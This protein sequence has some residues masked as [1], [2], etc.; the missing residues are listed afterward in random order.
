M[1]GVLMKRVALMI[2]LR[3]GTPYVMFIEAT[4]AKWKVLRVI[5]VLGSPID[6]AQMAPTASP[7]CTTASLYFFQTSWMNSS[8]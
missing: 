3:R 2:S 1:I 4:P 6:Y 8:N 5:Y 7:G